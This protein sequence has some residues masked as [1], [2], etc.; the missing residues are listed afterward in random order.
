MFSIVII[1]SILVLIFLLAIQYRPYYF[2]R[3]S[4]V[5]YWLL[6]VCQVV[7]N[8]LF[9]FTLCLCDY[10]S[11]HLQQAGICRDN[12]HFYHSPCMSCVLCML[13]ACQKL[14]ARF[15]CYFFVVWD[16]IR[17]YP[18]AAVV[19]AVDSSYLLGLVL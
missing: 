11:T 6:A 2:H 9:G 19:C 4:C 8:V 1:H 17:T 16:F 7:C 18:H 10:I 5:L 12:I 3:M 15:L 14:C 13:R